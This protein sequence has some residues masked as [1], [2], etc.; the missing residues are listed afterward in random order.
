MLFAQQRGLISSLFKL[1]IQSSKFRNTNNFLLASLS[2]Q[3][4]LGINYS[5]CLVPNFPLLIISLPFHAPSPCPSA[6]SLACTNPFVVDRGALALA[7]LS[8]LEGLLQ[9]RGAY[10][11]SCPFLRRTCDYN[12]VF[13]LFVHLESNFFFSLFACLCSFSPSSSCLPKS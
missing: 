6:L 10:K 12:L 3:T 1:T 7:K 2:L 11:P 5:F 13:S 8:I 9:L 4:K